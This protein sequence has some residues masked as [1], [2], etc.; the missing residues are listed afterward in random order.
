MGC[1]TLIKK[2]IVNIGYP[3]CGTS[4]LWTHMDVEP[5]NDKENRLLTTD[6]DFDQY[7]TYYNQFDVSA[8]FQTNLWCVDRE[9]IHFVQ[10]HASHITLV[11][12]NPY[13]FI[14]RY[15][16]WIDGELNP[17]EVLNF[18]TTA[19][20]VKY[21]DV[22]QRWKPNSKNFK[23]FFFED[24]ESNPSQ[25]FQNYMSFCELPIAKNQNI[26]YNKKINVN[27]KFKKTSLEFTNIQI[28]YIN[29]EIYKFQQLVDKDLSHWT[30]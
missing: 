4:W 30:R 27:P 14:E 15:Y 6:L 28:N 17:K 8:N 7:I 19:G 5:K 22:V 1:L 2:H 23:I 10:T 24:L 13:D 26:N 3:R 21:H 25:F 18:I 11:V 9:I 20:Y 29:Q 12:R 16:D